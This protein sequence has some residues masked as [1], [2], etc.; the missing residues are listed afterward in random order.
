MLLF[1]FVQ[2]LEMKRMSWPYI[3]K[4]LLE[5]NYNLNY[6]LL[7]LILVTLLKN[8]SE[9]KETCFLFLVLSNMKSVT[10]PLSEICPLTFALISCHDLILISR[11]NMFWVVICRICIVFIHIL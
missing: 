4:Y 10:T 1:I 9:K 5:S 3:L 6:V 2:F 7:E 11:S 8:A